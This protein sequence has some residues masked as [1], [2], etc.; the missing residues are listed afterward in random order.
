M[1]VRGKDEVIVQTIEYMGSERESSLLCDF[2]WW[3][4]LHLTFD[5]AASAGVG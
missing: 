3:L 4:G 2:T 1:V 5:Q